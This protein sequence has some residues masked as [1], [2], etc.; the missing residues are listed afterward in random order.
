M[1]CCRFHGRLPRHVPGAPPRR[2]RPPSR[3]AVRTPARH[4]ASKLAVRRTG[5]ALPRAHDRYDMRGACAATRGARDPIRF[6]VSIDVVACRRCAHRSGEIRLRQRHRVNRKARAMRRKPKR[7]KRHRHARAVT[8]VAIGRKC[9][10]N[11]SVFGGTRRNTRFA[12]SRIEIGTH[13]GRGWTAVSACESSLRSI[14]H[15]EIH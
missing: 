5:N 15:G 6:P 12:L 13:A 4:L 9:F 1:V 10:R 2:T 14:E 11:V 7:E 8:R 3:C